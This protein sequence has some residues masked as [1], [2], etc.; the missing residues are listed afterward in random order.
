MSVSDSLVYK[1]KPPSISG[2]THRQGVRAYNG[3]SFKGQQT[4]LINI[5]IPIG[6]RGH[7]LNTRMSYLKFKVTNNNTTNPFNL[8]YSAS[9]FI[10]SM[11]L[12]HGAYLLENINEYNALYHLLLD[13]QASQE[14]VERAGSILQ[15]TGKDRAGAAVAA[16]GSQTFC[17]PILSGIVGP[18]QS[19]YLPTGAMIGGDLR[20]ELVLANPTTAVVQGAGTPDWSVSDVEL[21]LEYVEV[22]S[23]VDRMIQQANPRYVIS[24]ETFANYTNTVPGSGGSAQQM[25]LLIPARF[26]SLKTLYTFFRVQGDVTSATA[27][28]VSS[29]PYPALTN[30]YYQV[31]GENVPATPVKDTVESFSELQKAMHV[32]GSADNT[33][34]IAK[35]DYN[36]TT[37]GNTNSSFAIGP[38]LETLSHKSTLTESGKNTLNTNVYLLG[39][40]NH[41]SALQ[42]STF[43]HVDMVLICENGVC[44]TAF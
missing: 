40:S 3:T 38:N 8:D 12:Y 43:A 1:P 21:Q 18:L 28:S 2:T 44:T 11:S 42:V 10:Q 19:K 37:G 32:F 14:S 22:N 16:S 4:I 20:L 15:G 17:I 36:L 13:M 9:A 26:S 24:Y 27:K 7:Y 33:S 5:Y 29:R 41:S 31:S 6:R 35:G 30:W 25:N 39:R 23:E 34:I